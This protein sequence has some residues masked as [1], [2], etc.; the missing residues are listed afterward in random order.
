MLAALYIEKGLFSESNI[1]QEK[2]IAM[3]KACQNQLQVSQVEIKLLAVLCDVSHVL[4][5]AAPAA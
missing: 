4:P 1:I 3:E 5:A 2:A